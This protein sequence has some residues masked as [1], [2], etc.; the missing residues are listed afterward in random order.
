MPDPA[1]LDL[2]RRQLDGINVWH[3]QR[4][5]QELAAL[6]ARTREQRLDRTRRMAVL[7]EEHRAIVAATEAQL[8][9]SR[10]LLP[11]TPRA[12]VAHRDDWFAGKLCERLEAF[13]VTVVGSPHN[14]AEAVGVV[15]AEQPDLV[16]V[17]DVLPM[18]SGADVVREV[19]TCAPRT[20]VAALVAHDDGVG[21]MI[22]AGALAA[23]VRRVPP[24]DVV[25]GLLALLRPRRGDHAD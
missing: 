2:A 18:L 14:G 20:L 13:G 9:A 8:R 7:C 17:E 22:E 3:R 6:S 19:L 4:R 1:G 5:A 15:V 23:F 24:A 11:Q 12:V 21:P 16:L 10:L 25:Q